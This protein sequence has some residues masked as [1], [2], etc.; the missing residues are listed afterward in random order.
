MTNRKNYEKLYRRKKETTEWRPRNYR[1]QGGDSG[2]GDDTRLK[3]S[4]GQDGVR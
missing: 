1:R 3:H 2:A 4:P